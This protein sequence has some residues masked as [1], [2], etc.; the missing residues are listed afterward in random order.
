MVS[1]PTEKRRAQWLPDGR[2]LVEG[3]LTR[4]LLGA[5]LVAIVLEAGLVAFLLGPGLVAIV[6]I[7]GLVAIMV[8]V[9]LGVYVGDFCSFVVVVEDLLE[10]E[11]LL[12]HHGGTDLA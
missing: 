11:A 3:K 2:G 4:R 7:A 5:G 9:G 8:W 1:S 10:C 6:P 12:A